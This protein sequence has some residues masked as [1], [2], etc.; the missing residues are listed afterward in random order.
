V[1]AQDCAQSGAYQDLYT[2]IP[3]AKH[4]FDNLD[5]RNETVYT[6]TGTKVQVRL[7]GVANGDDIWNGWTK[8]RFRVWAWRAGTL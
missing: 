4:N 2:H 5:R 3:P 7:W 8:T 1:V 6:I